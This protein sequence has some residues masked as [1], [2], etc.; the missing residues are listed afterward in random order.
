MTSK[1]WKKQPEQRP[2]GKP[3][4]HT[5]LAG[6]H[7]ERAPP[8]DTETPRAIP[9]CITTHG[10]H[11]H[12]LLMGLPSPSPTS[13]ILNLFFHP[14]ARK[15][16][17]KYKRG[18]VTSLL[19]ALKSVHSSQKKTLKPIA[20]PEHA[21]LPRAREPSPDILMAGSSRSPPQGRRPPPSHCTPPLI[22]YNF[23]LALITV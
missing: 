18:H 13:P 16:I 9:A 23:F 11:S 12:L 6:G 21:W 15:F 10:A 2:V 4:A 22:C 17:L 7:G 20:G 19:N 3:G 8:A 5:G 1:G 14:I